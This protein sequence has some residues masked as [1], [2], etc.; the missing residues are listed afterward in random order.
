LFFGADIISEDTEPNQSF[1]NL[2]LIFICMSMILPVSAES[3]GAKNVVTTQDYVKAT[4]ICS[5]GENN[6]SSGN[7]NYIY[8]TATFVNYCPRCKNYGTLK[9][10]PKGVPEGEWTCSKCNSDYCAADG[11][12]KI[13]GSHYI[14]TPYNPPKVQAQQEISVEINAITDLNNANNRSILEYDYNRFKN[15]NFFID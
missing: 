7:S 2:I 10:N 1:I 15:I 6:Y 11:R 12:E 13:T 9:Y 8:H 14:L 4:A 3:V 5:C